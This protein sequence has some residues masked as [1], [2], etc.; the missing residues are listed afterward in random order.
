MSIFIV[1][2]EIVQC[3]WY[4]VDV[5]GKI[6][7]CFVI[8]LVC[9]LCGKYKLVYILYVDIGDYLVVI[10]VEKIVVIGKK[11][12]DKMYYCF[13]GYIGNLKI[14]FLVQVLECYLE[15]VI[16]IVVKG[17]LLKGLLGCQMYCKFKVYVGI[18]YLYVVQQLQVLDI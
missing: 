11:L 2:N 9:C 5:E 4:F 16:E 18:E 13:I 6:L 8:E 17:M 15:C 14:E 3:D 10:N 7:G 12:Q 1:K